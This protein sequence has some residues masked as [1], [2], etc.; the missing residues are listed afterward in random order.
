MGTLALGFLA[1]W[2]AIAAYVGWLGMQQQ[3]LRRRL[4][5]AERDDVPKRSATRSLAA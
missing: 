5:A 3:R 1:A 2:G 4:D